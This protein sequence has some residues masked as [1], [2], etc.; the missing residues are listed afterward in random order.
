MKTKGTTVKG[1]KAKPRKQISKPSTTQSKKRLH[2]KTLYNKKFT[3]PLKKKRNTE[4]DA[5]EEA[6]YNYSNKAKEMISNVLEN[7]NVICIQVR[8][9]RVR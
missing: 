4:Y 5:K 9:N 6:R 1:N 8:K 7:R 3:A 2:T